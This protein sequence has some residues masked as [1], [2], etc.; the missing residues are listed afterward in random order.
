MAYP[1][2]NIKRVKELAKEGKSQCE[3]ERHTGIYR[4]EV[5]RILGADVSQ[6]PPESNNELSTRQRQSL[7]NWSAA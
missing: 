7:L 5:R 6:P 1:A 2:D 3:I 4:V